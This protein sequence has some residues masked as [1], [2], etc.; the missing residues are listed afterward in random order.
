L[1]TL[2]HVDLKGISRHTLCLFIGVM[3]SLGWR[4][5]GA[6]PLQHIHCCQ[7]ENC[8]LAEATLGKRNDKCVK[9][10]G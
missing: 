3:F 5:N 2:F 4:G 1:Q 8:P 6:H 9:K 7:T 10:N